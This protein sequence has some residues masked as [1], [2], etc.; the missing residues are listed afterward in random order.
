M[1][2]HAFEDQQGGLW[3]ALNGHGILR[4]DVPSQLS[5]YEHQL[6]LEGS[7][8]DM[9]RFEGSFYVATGSGLFVLE[10]QPIMPNRERRTRFMRIPDVP[11]TWSFSVIENQL[12]VTSE[13]GIYRIQG[14]QVRRVSDKAG[15]VLV[16]LQGTPHQRYLGT[17]DGLEIVNAEGPAWVSERAAVDVNQ[18]RSIIEEADGT[19]WMG[20][21]DGTVTR[22]ENLFSEH[23]NIQSYGEENG[24]PAHP[25]FL[26]KIKDDLVVST[27]AGIYRYVAGNEASNQFVLDPTLVPPASSAADSILAFEPDAAGDLWVARPDGVHIGRL[28]ADGSYDFESPPALQFDLH[29]FPQIYVEPD[30]VA[31]IGH[32]NELIRYDAHI[33]KTYNAPYQAA[34]REVVDMRS[35]R[36]MYGGMGAAAASR[37]SSE[38]IAY[39]DNTLEFQYAAP[40]Y[41]RPEETQYQYF[42]EGKDEDWSGWTAQTSKTYPSLREGNYRFRVRAV[43]GQG[44]YGEEAVLNF[45]ILPP[46]YRT[47]WAFS[48]YFVMLISAL[49]L[50]HRYQVAVT[51]SRK[52]Q[53]HAEELARERMVNERLQEVNLRLQE[54]NESLLQANRLKDEFLANTS[55]ELRTPLT[56]ILGFTSIMRDEAEGQHREFLDLI[57]SNGERLLTTVNSLLDLARIRA[58]MITLS[59]E[60]TNVNTQVVNVV[61]LLSPLAKQKNLIFTLTVK[62]D[63]LYARLDPHYLDRI[64]YNIIG[65]AIKF[66][67]EGRVEVEVGLEDAMVVVQV[68][69]TGVGISEAFMPELFVEF[70]QESTGFGRSHEGSGLGLAI[71]SHLVNLMGGEIDVESTKG[72]GSI[73]TVRLPQNYGESVE[74][75]VGM[76]A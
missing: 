72:A 33:E 57:S 23:L 34:I 29:L 16:A 48:L 40:T 37:L 11:Q 8:R 39:D 18:V 69:D 68:L 52:A 7:V 36:T 2:N 43:N 70:Q 17:Y 65:N 22:V 28:Q 21:I 44:I 73:F 42:L 24:L 50:G 41:N 59:N 74:E 66:T 25:A 26:E 71:T 31:W 14:N 19:L 62:D 49:V 76:T 46:W 32:G 12:Y 3:L 4:V 61:R 20:S 9:I 6:G 67:E 55:H 15:F 5:Y 75:E 64:L 60:V 38:G 35:R 27:R 51:E 53:E 30:G 54:A 58:G 10:H 13:G 63:P 45:R 47:W 1:V 56:A